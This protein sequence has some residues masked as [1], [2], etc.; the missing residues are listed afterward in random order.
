[1]LDYKIVHLRKNNKKTKIQMYFLL[2]KNCIYSNIIYELHEVNY[3]GR[4]NEIEKMENLEDLFDTFLYPEDIDKEIMDAREIMRVN[5]LVDKLKLYNNNKEELTNIYT[6]ILMDDNVAYILTKLSQNKIFYEHFPEFYV[7]NDYGEN[8]FNCQQN[9]RFHRY[10]VFKHILSTIENIG[11]VQSNYDDTQR[12]VLKWTMLLHDIGKPYVKIIAEDGSESFAGHDDKSVELGKKILDRFYFNEEEKE[13]ILKL[14]KYHDRFINEGEITDDNMKFLASDLDNN[15]DVFYLLLDVKE[16]DARAKCI[17]VYNTF[18]ILRAKYL[19][20]ITKYFVYN[21]ENNN[22]ENN[23]QANEEK[24]DDFKFEKMSNAEL[25]QLLESILSRKSIKSVYQPVI[26][27]NKQEVCAYEVFTRIE[28]KKRVNIL[29]FFNYAV[30]TNKYE[31]LQQTL[32]INGIENFETISSKESRMLFV[33]ADYSS[34]EKYVNKPRLYDMMG[35]NKIVIEFQ[36]YNKVNIEKLQDTINKIHEH[37]GLVSLDKFGN[38][39]TFTN[40]LN[41]IN[42]DYLTT[43]ISLIKN[44]ADDLERQ[45]KLSDLVTFCLSKDINL[46]VVGVEDK[47]TLEYVNKLGVRFV[48]GYYFAK[49]DFKIMNINTS[50]KEKLEEFNQETIS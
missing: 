34:Y 11:S 31:K 41:F 18:K 35:R 24:N 15:K 32:L 49:P 16:A 3:M 10:G 28:S 30:E 38:N 47:I 1:M 50:V 21:E 42:V 17:D 22:T 45:R 46:L 5:N 40:E 26:D 36:N 39:E 7:F 8:L 43:D 12:K 9:S 48:Q 27:L 6:S 14:V 19:E 2:K 20:F 37:G 23:N 44:I 33:N 29:D 13:L 25:G 4:S